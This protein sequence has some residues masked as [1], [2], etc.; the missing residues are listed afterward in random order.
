MKSCEQSMIAR[1]QAALIPVI[2]IILA[3]F[4]YLQPGAHLVPGLDSSWAYAL[5]YTFQQ[6]LI[7]GRDIYFTFGPLGFLEHTRPLS[8]QLLVISSIFWFLC[9]V[10][11]YSLILLLCLYA[12]K[13]KVQIFVNLSLALLVIFYANEIIQRLLLI[14]YSGI[15][16]HW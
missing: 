15:F 10:I 11:S 14:L 13:N 3:L 4:T 6:K 9:A 2:G 16:L 7:I 12:A 5:N 1:W 8:L